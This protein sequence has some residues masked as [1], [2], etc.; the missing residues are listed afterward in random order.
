MLL[1]RVKCHKSSE[2]WWHCLPCRVCRSCYS[3]CEC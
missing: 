1:K 3:A 2:G